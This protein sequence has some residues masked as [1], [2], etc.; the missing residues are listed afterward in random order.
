MNYK[1]DVFT[2]QYNIV[3]CF[4]YHMTYYRTLC[5]GYTERRLHNRFWHMAIE[6]HLFAA[7]INWCMVF[8]SD[9]CNPTHWK[10]LSKKQSK[11]L[12]Q[13]FRDGLFQELNLDK[14]AWEKYWKSFKDFRDNFVA[15]R[16]LNFSRPVPNF[17]TAL[18]VAY[19]YDK[20]V[21]KIISPDTLNEP[22]LEQFTILQ[23]ELVT[24]LVD[25]LLRVTE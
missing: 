17:D 20:W 6:A 5:K 19:F 7:T 21:R 23:E 3:D 14:A 18:D 16:E 24:P 15:H 13:S 11:E 4:I 8:G 22:S 1:Q 25:K 10:R 12:I 9:G 2:H